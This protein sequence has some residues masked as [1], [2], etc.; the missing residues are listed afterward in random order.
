VPHPSTQPEILAALES[1]AGVLA[2]FFE[3]QP[4]SALFTGDP[5]HWGPA[6]HLRHLTLTSRSITSGLRSAR[7]PSHS[8][9]VSRSYSELIGAAT[10]S[11]G[12]ASKER[13]LE[14][15]RVVVIPSGTT[16]DGMVEDY[17]Q[18]STDLRTAAAAWNDEDLDRHTMPHPFLGT[19]TVREMLLFCVFHERHHLRLVRARLEPAA[20]GR[21]TAGG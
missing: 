13:L 19:V 4:E 12:A 20:G 18:A 3:A 7:L 2:S 9:G 21:P 14:N 8:T 5:G 15:G 1:N 17:V 16:R 10:A 11:L 6:H